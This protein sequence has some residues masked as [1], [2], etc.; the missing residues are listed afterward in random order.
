MNDTVMFVKNKNK[1]TSTRALMNLVGWLDIKELIN[2]HT[3]LMMVRILHLKS[4]RYFV[5]KIKLEEDNTISTS[6]PHIQNTDSGFCW[7]SI[8]L[9]NSLNLS[10]RQE[11]SYPKKKKKKKKLFIPVLYNTSHRR[12]AS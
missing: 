12:A 11:K 8:A 1:R 2:F 5:D 7:R 4:P 3:I 10:L 9:W 6:S